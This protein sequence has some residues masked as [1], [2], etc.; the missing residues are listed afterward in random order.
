[1]NKNDACEGGSTFIVL[2]G[3]LF[4]SIRLFAK[5]TSPDAAMNELKHRDEVFLLFAILLAKA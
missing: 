2:A 4:E 5:K 3:T 1:V